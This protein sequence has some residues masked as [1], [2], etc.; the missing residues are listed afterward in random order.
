MKFTKSISGRIFMAVVICV[1]AA[2]STENVRADESDIIIPGVSVGNVDIGG[3]TREEAI[4]KVQ[5]YMTSFTN[6]KVTLMVD[7]NT[8]ETTIGEIGYYWK[9]T[10]V[11]DR[12]EDLCKKGNIIERYKEKKDIEAK[13]VK[14]ELEVG[15]NDDMMRQAID[16]YCSEYNVPHVNASMTKTGDGFTYTEESAGRIIDVDTTVNEFH[17]FL[18]NTWDGN[19]AE[20]KVTMIDDLPTATIADCQKVTDILGTYSTTFSTGSGNYNRNCN[21]E[22]GSRLMNGIIVY[23]GETFSANALLEPWTYDNGWRE[24]GTYVNGQVENSLGGGICQVSSTLYN[25]VLEAELEIV[26]RYPHSMSVG[27]VPLSQDA[28]LAGT[29][30]DLK[31]ANNTDAP[32][33][34]ESYCGRGTV[35]FNI[36]GHETRDPNRT[37]EY[38]SETLGTVQPSES[39]TEDPSLPQGYRNV[40]SSGHVGYTARL[41]KKVYENGTLVSEEIV[42]KSSYEASPR[43][44]V[45]GTGAPQ[46]A[47]GEGESQSQEGDP[48]AQG[49]NGEGQ[50]GEGQDGEGQNGEGQNGEGQNGEG[51]DG[52]GQNGEGQDGEGNKP[53]EPEKETKKDDKKKQDSGDNKQEENNNNED[54]NNG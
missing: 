18:L 41:W 51:Q 35:T 49:Q 26:E 23:P 20:L 12:A 43:K 47:P 31:F 22:N 19:D 11:I 16:T 33:Y 39:V 8:A 45:V 48:N 32:I 42:N 29:W 38:V 54:N 25:A 53:Q 50:N 21:I 40:V 44:V 46:P 1:F 52:E 34:I 28:A 2:F 15:V 30:K 4:A 37:F 9:N 6:K 3:L 13:G 17:Q 14:Y 5:E 24:A 7:E 10:S 27:Y 36:Y